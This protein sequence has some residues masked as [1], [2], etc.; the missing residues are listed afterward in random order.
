MLTKNKTDLI[1]VPFDFTEQAMTAL[2]H[3]TRIARQSEDEIR[4]LHIINSETR[5]KLKK[6]P[7]EV[8]ADLKQTADANQAAKGVKTSYHAEEGSIFTT[9][10]KYI[11]DS[12]ASLVVMGTHGVKGIQH[13]IGP[14]SLRVV[15]SSPVPIIVVQEKKIAPHGYKKIVLPI[16]FHKSGKNRTAYAIA[17]AKYFS[18]EVYLFE[19]TVADEFLAKQVTLNASHAINYLEENKISY[20]Q[21]KE[22][23]SGGSFSKQVVRYASLI[24]ADLIVVSS[25]QD[26]DSVV[27]LIVGSK[28]IDIINN[29]AQIAVMCVNPVQNI[30]HLDID[31]FNF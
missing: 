12:G 22:A 21:E 2:D 1:V 17:I 30:S 5:N 11:T 18:S 20:K 19:Q 10:G 29:D 27:D 7:E 13:L 3:A 28:E 15:A 24:A 23:S 25:E 26:A 14:N 4:L 16:D 8:L 9:M 6:T 31:S